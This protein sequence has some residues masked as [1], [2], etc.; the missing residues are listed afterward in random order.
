MA[1]G[2]KDSLLFSP[3]NLQYEVA[4]DLQVA[5]Q[6]SGKQMRFCKTGCEGKIQNAEIKNCRNKKYKEEIEKW[7]VEKWIRENTVFKTQHLRN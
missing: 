6:Y 2:T 4:S 3:N 5:Q 1:S 7:K